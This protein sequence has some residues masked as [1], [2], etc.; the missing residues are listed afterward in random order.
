MKALFVDANVFLRFFTRDDAGRHDKATR[1][2]RDA[3]EGKVSLVTGPPVLFEIAWTLR[4]AYDRSRSDVLD[5]L[6]SMLSMEGLRLTDASVCERALN[7]ARSSGVE[8][9]DAYIA[10]LAEECGVD[11]VATF[12]IA[13]FKKLN[14]SC[15]VFQ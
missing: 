12:N 3:V 11:S 1:L 14:V 2:F 5:V 13:D 6:E 10:A 4:S 9:P 8:F 7:L 15:H